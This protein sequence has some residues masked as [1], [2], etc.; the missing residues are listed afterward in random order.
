MVG[1][2][3]VDNEGAS[4]PWF[5]DHADWN[6]LTPADLIFPGFIFI[7]GVAV[8]LAVSS[9]NPIKPRTILRIIG[10]FVIGMLLSLIN[11]KFNF[12]RM[13]IMGVLQR[14][15]L[16]YATVVG[17]HCLTFYGS[18]FRILGGIFVLACLALYLAFM[19][20]F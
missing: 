18:R 7:M 15:S 17:I 20:P 4:P 2:I 10:L 16:S 5:I 11:H 3:L 19:I 1:M 8:P 14:I 6:G 9:K 13:R 12:E